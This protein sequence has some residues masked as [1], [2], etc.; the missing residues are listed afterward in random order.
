V[1]LLRRS[2][3]IRLSREYV[4]RVKTDEPTP[5]ASDR[6]N[7]QSDDL[8]TIRHLAWNGELNIT[9]D[10]NPL[11]FMADRAITIRTTR[12]EDVL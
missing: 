8:P 5:R 3:P 9:L 6:E 2:R 10:G 12:G 4:L 11:V 7:G 1:K